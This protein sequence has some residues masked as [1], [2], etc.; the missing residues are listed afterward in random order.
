MTGS[1]SWHI[2]PQGRD[3]S[4]CLSP[5]DKQS[6]VKRLS[7]HRRGFSSVLAVIFVALF[8][9]LG[10]SFFS[11]TNINLIMA[12]NHYRTAQAQAVAESGLAY[13]GYLIGRYIHD[14]RPYTFEQTLS[15]SEMAVLFAD[16]SDHTAF[17]LDD[18]PAI[19]EGEVGSLTDFSEDGLTGIQFS[20]PVI[21]INQNQECR[22]CLQFRQY[23]DAPESIEVTSTGISNNIQRAIRLSHN[24]VKDDPG[25]FDFALFA[26]DDLTFHNAVT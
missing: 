3:E 24:I 17:L 13:A 10:I 6:R 14:E 2:E 12:D 21:R 4:V 8:S 19:A 11:M 18:S 15:Q 25:L 9:V 7:F 23:A 1:E 20:V 16:F 22:F 5:G 26:R